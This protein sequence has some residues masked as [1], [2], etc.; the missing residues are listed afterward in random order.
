[1]LCWWRDK[2]FTVA[3]RARA[4]VSLPPINYPARF[5]PAAATST[6]LTVHDLSKSFPGVLALDEVS[7]SF[8][9]G[10]VHGVIGENG[11]GKSTLMNILAGV[12]EPTAG[13]LRM[14]GQP[15][16]VG[17]VQAAAAGGIVMIHQE[18]NLI[19][20]LSV[21]DN[22]FLGR[23]FVRRGLISGSRTVGAAQAVLASFGCEL[24]PRAKVGRLSIA[25]KQMVEI[26]KA[27]SQ[28]AKV[29]IMDE[30][31]AVLTSNEVT[32][33]FEL[34]GELRSRGVC[35]IYISH[36]LPEVLTICD[37]VTV[38]RDGRRVTTL[39]RDEIGDGHEA[40]AKLASLMVGREMS[41][42][43]PPRR[44]HRE[45]VVLSVRGLSCPPHVRDVRFDLHDGEVLG[46]AGLIGA[47]RTE[48]AEAIAGL[49]KTTPDP[50]KR[51]SGVVFVEGASLAARGPL[52]AVRAGVCYLS[53]DRKGA[54]LNLSMSIAANTTL[55]SLK[56]Y[57]H[58]LISPREERAAAQ[59]H[60]RRLRTKTTDVRDP[61]E[62]LSGG[63]QQK[64]ALAKWLE[65]SPKVLILDEPT[66]GVDIGAKEEI[67]RL[68]QEL[69]QQGMSCVFISSEINELLGMAHRI[70]VMRGGRV[71]GIVDGSSATEEDVMHLAAGVGE[72]ARGAAAT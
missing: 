22:I 45:G 20:E 72:A 51:G 1:M 64:V 47:G 6:E 19:D 38:L 62:T 60:V 31:T 17:S 34:V 2:N 50:L 25:E 69:T 71:A 65:M 53:E 36:I 8:R 12:H 48:M 11:A 13:Q 58:P 24:D 57:C 43:F 49:R 70:V 59:R 35:V 33:L 10:Q 46:F 54:G 41:E 21:A 42:H 27:L 15:L 18:L 26:A 37:R 28:D 67:Y 14:N 29:L 68:I 30:P 56:R 44:P 39:R 55:V 32:K 66:R 52:D 63:N 3:H 7:L 61:V 5:M 16:A 4:V 40:E 9:G 23:E